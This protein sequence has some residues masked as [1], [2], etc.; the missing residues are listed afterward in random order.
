ME[1]KTIN[2]HHP[3]VNS[4]PTRFPQDAFDPMIEQTNELRRI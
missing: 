1:S 4:K 2:T 3:A